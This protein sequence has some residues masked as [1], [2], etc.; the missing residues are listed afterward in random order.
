MHHA[1]P[2]GIHHSCSRKAVNHGQSYPSHPSTASTFAASSAGGLRRTE[3]IRIQKHQGR[4]CQ[5][6]V[7]YVYPSLSFFIY[8][9]L[10]LNVVLVMQIVFSV[11]VLLETVARS[12]TAQM[13]PQLSAGLR[14]CWTWCCTF[15]WALWAF[16]RLFGESVHVP[17]GKISHS[18]SLAFQ[19]GK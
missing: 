10:K 7:G 17:C 8:L 15:R 13:R 18:H 3:R 9:F 19:L 1:Y 6:F 12:P 11:A 5:S 2:A 16:P 14:G 4:L